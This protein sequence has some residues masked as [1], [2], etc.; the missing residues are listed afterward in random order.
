MFLRF[1]YTEGRG[2]IEVKSDIES[3]MKSNEE[4]LAKKAVE[5]AEIG[6]MSVF[7]CEVKDL[8]RMAGRDLTKSEF[9]SLVMF[10]AS[11]AISEAKDKAPPN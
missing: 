10:G 9:A 11:L 4:S 6:C 3:K 1:C 5:A 2:I 7:H 8:I